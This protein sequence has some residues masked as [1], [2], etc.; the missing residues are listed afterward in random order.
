MES[1]EINQDNQLENW[2][3]AENTKVNKYKQPISSD[4]TDSS[5]IKKGKSM[6]D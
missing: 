3:I 5:K 1:I 6:N 4:M 2:N